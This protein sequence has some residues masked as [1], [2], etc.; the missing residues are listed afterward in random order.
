MVKTDKKAKPYSVRKAVREVILAPEYVKRRPPQ[1]Q[2]QYK[3]YMDW[4]GNFLKHWVP[5]P[6][7]AYDRPIKKI[8]YDLWS[9]TRSI[10]PKR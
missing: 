5:P 7:S 10:W 6:K 9:D 4:Q 3:H 2:N 1:F 8:H